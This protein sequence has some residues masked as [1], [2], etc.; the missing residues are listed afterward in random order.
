M[1]KP[2]AHRR[3]GGING[4]RGRPRATVQLGEPVRRPK[5][6]APGSRNLG[7]LVRVVR[8]ERRGE[9]VDLPELLDLAACFVCRAVYG[10]VRAGFGLLDQTLVFEPAQ[11]VGEYAVADVLTL[12][13]ADELCEIATALVAIDE[14]VKDDPVPSMSQDARKFAQAVAVQD[15]SPPPVGSRHALHAPR[16]DGVKSQGK[17]QAKGIV[18]MLYRLTVRVAAARGLCEQ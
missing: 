5:R 6:S 7:G 2:A 15:V 9:R 17:P 8:A 11:R 16:G 1:I 14:L 3:V 10:V 12:V 4:H 13:V 18:N